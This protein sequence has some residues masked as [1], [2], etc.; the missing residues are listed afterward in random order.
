MLEDLDSVDWASL[1]HA[2]GSAE[3]VPGHIRKLMSDDPADWVEAID[4]LY[5]SIYH[6]GTVYSATGSAVP[7]L[8]QLTGTDGIR[9]R[10]RILELLAEIAAGCS[11]LDVHGPPPGAEHGRESPEFQA[12]LAE[13]LEWVRAARAAVWEGWKLLVHH[14]SDPDRRI[15]LAAGYTLGKLCRIRPEEW[16]DSIREGDVPARIATALRR[17]LSEEPDELVKAGQVFALAPLAAR[18]HEIADELRRHLDAPSSR[19]VELAAAICLVQ[20]AEDPPVEAIDVLARAILAGAEI[21]NLFDPGEASVEQRHQPLAKAY[22]RAGMPIAQT[23]G[24]DYDGEDAGAEEDF[25][26]PWLNPRLRIELIWRLCRVPQRHLDRILPALLAAL[27][28][29]SPYTVDYVSGPILRYVFDG[30]RVPE[31]AKAGDLTP[32]QRAALEILYANERLFESSSGNRNAVFRSLGLPSVRW[33]WE[34]LLGK[35]GW[36]T[37]TEGQILADLDRCVRHSAKRPEATPV[38]E[39]DRTRLKDIDLEEVLGV[40]AYLPYLSRFP[41]LETLALSES[42][43]TDDGLR[44]LPVLA[45]LKGIYLYGTSITDEGA[46]ALGRMPTLEV[47]FVNKTGITDEGVRRLAESLPRLRVLSLI[48]TTT[49]DAAVPWLARLPRIQELHLDMT[50][51]SREGL[52]TLRQCL[53]HC[54]ISPRC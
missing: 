2:Y 37:D 38:T 24:D 50:S 16:P 25:R 45:R 48:A 19:P 47:V 21:D 49:T 44:A 8:I 39:E 36:P 51:V 12:Q 22:Q 43:V 40:D 33:K 32:P 23:V 10:A 29:E 28:D 13:E 30:R 7:F 6:Q 20:W 1:D 27:R 53:P 18:D 5:W 14:L 41:N 34:R 26:F 54:R 52:E 31:T 35:A 4:A 15:R 42:G 46:A 11:Y 3:D 9:C 17:R